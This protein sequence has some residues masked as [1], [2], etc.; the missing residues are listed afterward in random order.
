MLHIL[1]R[2][3]RIK[4][5]PEKFQDSPEKYDVVLTCE[6][7]VYDLVI[8]KFE[9]GES[10]HSHMAHV[11]NIDVVRQ[12]HII[13]ISCLFASTKMQILQFRVE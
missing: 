5:R 4:E 10:S 1:D 3:R 2:N 11:I 12:F 8:E 13:F 9:S 6:E 7:R